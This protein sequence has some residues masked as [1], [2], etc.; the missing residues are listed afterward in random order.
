MFRRDTLCI[1]RN[2]RSLQQQ[3]VLPSLFEKSV[4]DH[5]VNNVALINFP[6][7]QARRLESA[8][9]HLLRT[10]QLS[11]EMWAEK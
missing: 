11:R 10:V 9:G 6:V 2:V 3:H 7:V 4:A 5:K 1:G 8:H